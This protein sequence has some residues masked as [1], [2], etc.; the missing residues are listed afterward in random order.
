MATMLDMSKEAAAGQPGEPPG[1]PFEQMG[2]APALQ[3][4]LRHF[5]ADIR[6][7]SVLG[8]IFNAQITDWPAHLEKIGS[9]WARQTGAASDY[10]GGFAAAHLRL[11]IQPAHFTR[12]LGLWERNCRQ[13]LEPASAEWMI[14]RAHELG[15]HLRRIVAGA[16]GLQIGR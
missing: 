11:G 7:D 6:Q 13:H 8:P 3:N 10:A 2:G 1:T 14:G 12:W 16:A 4:L 15:A 9:F 5:Y